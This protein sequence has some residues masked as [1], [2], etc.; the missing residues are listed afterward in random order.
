MITAPVPWSASISVLGMQSYT[1]DGVGVRGM[2]HPT[3]DHG[4]GVANP[5]PVPTK[6][7]QLFCCYVVCVSHSFI[8]LL[9]A[10]MADLENGLWA[11][12]KPKYI[13]SNVTGEWSRCRMVSCVFRASSLFFKDW[14][15]R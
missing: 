13:N 2:A 5:Y 7:T 8:C 1:E 6:C 9:R 10:V 4:V 12:D 3:L 15:V 14:S 11:C